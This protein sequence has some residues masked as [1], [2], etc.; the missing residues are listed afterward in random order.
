MREDCYYAFNK[1][2]NQWRV[3]RALKYGQE[4]LTELVSLNLKTPDHQITENVSSNLPN[5]EENT[6]KNGKLLEPELASP[7]E[8]LNKYIK[9][10]NNYLDITYGVSVGNWP[11]QPARSR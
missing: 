6:C 8:R 11:R 1:D 3:S 7:K 5:V 4:K 2:F 9:K 10:N